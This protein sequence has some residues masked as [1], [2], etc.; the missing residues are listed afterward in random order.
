M[1]TYFI[2]ELYS[3]GT[4]HHEHTLECNDEIAPIAVSQNLFK[5]PHFE[6]DAIRVLTNDGEELVCLGFDKLKK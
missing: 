6:A 2:Q 3:D 4:V 1:H 5:S